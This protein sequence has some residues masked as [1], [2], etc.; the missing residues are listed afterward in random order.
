MD[1]GGMEGLTKKVT[2]EQRLGKG[3]GMGCVDFWKKSVVGIS[4]VM[5]SSRPRV[6]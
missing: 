3:E 4:Q 6:I 2:F 1:F 5:V